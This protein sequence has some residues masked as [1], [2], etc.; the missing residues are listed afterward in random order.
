MLISSLR[1]LFGFCE[2]LIK[3]FASYLLDMCVFVSCNFYDFLLFTPSSGVPQGSNLGPLLFLLLLNDIYIS[4][5]SIPCSLQT[6]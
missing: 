4:L 3:L 5:F 2:R 1:Y 6:A